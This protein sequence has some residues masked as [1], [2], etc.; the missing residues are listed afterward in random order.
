[1]PLEI[2]KFSRHNRIKIC[3]DDLETATSKGFCA[4]QNNWFYGYKLHGVCLVSGVFH[5]LD[6]KN[7]SVHDIHFLKN[8]KQKMSD[9]VDWGQR[10]FIFNNTVGFI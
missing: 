3:K 7:A 4:S 5:S 2:C 6:I 10:V 8:I 1:M 9:C